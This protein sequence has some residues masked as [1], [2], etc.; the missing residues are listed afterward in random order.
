METTST[1]RPPVMH[2]HDHVCMYVRVQL[3]RPDCMRMHAIGK[4][5]A[6]EVT[7]EKQCKAAAFPCI[8]A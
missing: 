4:N 6:I 2:A 3:P 7:L 8:E 1:H 5:M